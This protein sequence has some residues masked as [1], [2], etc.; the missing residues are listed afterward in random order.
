MTAVS[1]TSQ[2]TG[3]DRILIVEDEAWDAEL[4]QRL[5]TGA[6]L[7]YTAVVVDTRSAFTD[8]LTE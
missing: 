8:Q 5:L 2:N 3:P 7:A 4:A 1:G 6:G